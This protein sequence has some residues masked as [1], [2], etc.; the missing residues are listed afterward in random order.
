LVRLPP[1]KQRPKRPKSGRRPEPESEPPTPALTPRRKWLFR[2]GALV[3]LPLLLL[4]V[5]EGGL[6]VAGF[7]YSTRLF[8]ELRIGHQD[9]LVN[10]DQFGLR[11]F[12]PEMTRSPAAFKLEAKK[13]EGVCRI[14]ILGESAA[15][16]DPEP[17]F[18]AGRYLEVLLRERFPGTKFEVI[19]L[20]VTA[21]N[22]HVIVPIA[23][24]CA[25]QKADV[26]IIYM[27][28]NEMV[29]PFGAATVFGRQAAPWWFVR[30]NLS[31]QKTRVGQL[32]ATCGRRLKGK[33]SDSKA[34]G[35]MQMFVENKVLPDDRRKQVVYRNFQRNL[36]DIVRAGLDSG[37]KIIL[38]A[39]AVNLK[40]CPP[41]AS[42]SASNNLASSERSAFDKFY[43]D[44]LAAKA[45]GRSKEAAA[46]FAE[47]AKLDSHSADLQF[48]WA[49][50]LL[51]LT[52][53]AAAQQHFQLACDWDPLP[54]RADARI[55]ALIREIG[56][57]FN[58]GGLALFDAAAAL[59]T[60]NPAGVPGKE[61]FYEHVHFDFDGSYHLARAWA[62]QVE[63]LVPL[64]VANPAA[65]ADW[66]TQ[67][68]CERRLGLTDWN[69]CAVVESVIRRMNEPPL[70]GQINNGLR[71]NA[72]RSRAK[73][74]RQSMSAGGE[75]KA[76]EIYTEALEHAPDD[77]YLHENF[78]AFLLARGELPEATAQWRR[79]H[80]LMP[81]DFIAD[82]RLG[83]VLTKSGRF[84]Q[85]E[86]ALFPAVAAHPGF[87]EGWMQLGEV[88]AA[89]E[90][91][92]LALKEYERAR[93]L[94]PQDPE[95]HCSLG[96][97]LARLNRPAESIAAFREAV[98]LKPDD[99]EAHYLLGGELGLNNQVAE[100]KSEFEEAVRLKPE[101]PM[102]HLNLGVALMK[103]GR[104][105]DAQ[106]QFE[107]TLRL[108]P[109][110]KLARNYL[111][112]AQAMRKP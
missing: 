51:A 89:Q 110:N 52:N 38:N 39:V 22:S 57:Q 85:A 36:T 91:L 79:V 73:A 102:A 84:A 62:E 65:N 64:T 104:F 94:R 69:R 86:S 37:A 12:P 107:E 63:R 23:R 50:C 90:K 96:R 42:A 44:G 87:T 40:D 48:H 74:L 81:Q 70:S 111:G 56:G 108:D 47:A 13:P 24:E 88:H 49:E 112:R 77:Y 31:I 9:Y 34:W 71:Q 28:N 8:Q 55:N 59:A 101:Y 97:V 82:Y 83:E 105:E 78:A 19:N 27:G 29:G 46:R 66:A 11:F 7:G 92:V 61:S 67:A 80:E 106:R 103:Q 6:R 58:G 100:A 60:N 95:I 75:A 4:G 1:L 54:F 76:R 45:Q 53:P 93:R 99:P 33:S 98:R 41:F 109:G 3:L 14:F 43:S 16:G 10:N 15:M 26:W 18:G 25:G 2:L 32:L 35:G 21:I 72:L 68:I 30:L 5:L 17:A 20:G